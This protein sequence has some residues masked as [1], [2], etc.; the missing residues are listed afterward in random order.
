MSAQYDTIAAAYS[1]TKLTPLRQHVEA[2]SYAAMLGD[3]RGLRVLDLAC[4][5]GFYTRMLRAMGAA[6]VIG[7]DISAAMIARAEA[8]EQAEPLGIRYLCA[9]AAALSAAAEL[10]RFDLISA[11]FLLHYAPSVA[12]LRAMCAELAAHLRSGGRLVS[13]N[14]NPQQSA[15]LYSGYTQYGF[16]KEYAE[17]QCDGS[18]IRYALVSGRDMVTF[19]AY[20]YSL[21]TYTAALTAAGFS[22]PAWIPLRVSPAGVEECGADYYAAYLEH[23]PVVGLECT[24][25]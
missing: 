4:G 24:R 14:E 18:L 6:E 9:D 16:N 7:V 10:G 2:Y 5:D 19:D 20:F 8:A 12:D 13:L 21:A 17:P 11:A 15:E 1:R 22:E 23:P 25:R 3:V